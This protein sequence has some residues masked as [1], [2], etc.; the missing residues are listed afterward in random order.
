VINIVQVA[1]V[2][3]VRRREIPLILAGIG[4]SERGVM[5]TGVSFELVGEGGNTSV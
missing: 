3:R 2:W 4:V 5:N 1:A